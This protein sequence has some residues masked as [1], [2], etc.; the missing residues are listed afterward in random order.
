[1]RDT[2]MGW[3]CEKH[4]CERC[5]YEM[6]TYERHVYERRAHKR[7]VYERHIYGRCTPMRWSSMVCIPCK[8]HA[9]EA[10]LVRDTPMRDGMG[11]PIG[12]TRL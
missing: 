6:A 4:T 7:H 10:A 5:V 3:S 8:M 1:M 2:P 12:D 9:C 11:W